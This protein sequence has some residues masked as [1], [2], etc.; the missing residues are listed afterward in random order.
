MKTFFKKYGIHIFIILF[1][2]I[3]I[4][5][6][7]GFSTIL[8]IN[9]LYRIISTIIVFY[10]G[11][12]IYKYW[13][14]KILVYLMLILLTINFFASLVARAVYKTPFDEIQGTSVLLTNLREASGML[15][16]YVVY[17][18]IAVLYFLLAVF[19][20]KTLLNKKTDK[21]SKG[22][23]IIVMTGLV[24][25]LAF[26][27]EYFVKKDDQRWSKI[28]GFT[29]LLGK[30]AFFNVAQ[31]NE[32]LNLLEE[33]EMITSNHVNYSDIK[34]EDNNIENIIVILGESAR[35]DALSLYGNPVKTTPNID[36]RKNEL[37]IYNN[38]VSPAYFTILAV[39]LMIS[40]AIPK[41]D[42][43]IN[44][45]SDNVINLANHTNKWNTY[46][47]SSQEKAGTHSNAISAIASMSKKHYWNEN[48][49][50]E[51]LL[52]FLYRSI[53]DK[54]SKRL[55]FLHL[56]GSHYPT[57]DRYPSG[58]N[59]FQNSKEQFVNEYYNSIY[60]TDYLIEQIIKKV[61]LT[62]SVL[63]YVSDHGQVKGRNAYTHALAKKGLD[64]P[65]FIW[66]SKSVEEKYRNAGIISDYVSTT[67]LYEII[68]KYMGVNSIE[69]KPENKDLKILSGEVK[70]IFYKDLQDGDNS[71]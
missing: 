24:L 11:V 48:K 23:L 50:D 27:V 33:F 3:T 36:K 57:K 8:F 42:F 32:A 44:E 70:P 13:V 6:N 51:S 67:E 31:L 15:G 25:H 28:S 30:T 5:L 16:G 64:V 46:W 18:L 49:Y 1:S 4:I 21:K 20:F 60:Y 61:E 37:L 65:F 38:A 34:V 62:S 9:N 56:Y 59:V 19:L 12:L 47:F 45:I 10:I 26:T 58:F 43:A 66:H 71:L 63:I 52:P 39:P 35:K 40:K 41:D 17:L 22:Y 69:R 2:G 53:N 68:K 54:S 7:E 29:K 55:I 14:G